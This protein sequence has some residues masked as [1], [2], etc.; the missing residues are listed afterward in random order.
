VQPPH[1][2]KETVFKQH[3]WSS[4]KKNW[5]VP[6]DRENNAN[7]NSAEWKI[8]SKILGPFLDMLAARFGCARVPWKWYRELVFPDANF[9]GGG[10]FKDVI[11]HE[12]KVE[13]KDVVGRWRAG[14]GT[15]WA[16]EIKGWSPQYDSN[17]ED[18]QKEWWGADQTAGMNMAEIYWGRRQTGEDGEEVSN[19]MGAC[20]VGGFDASNYVGPRYLGATNVIAK[21]ITNVL[22]R[23]SHHYDQK[24]TMT[25]NAYNASFYSCIHFAEL[26]AMHLLVKRPRTT[27]KTNCHCTRWRC[28]DYVFRCVS[29]LS[30]LRCFLP[31]LCCPKCKSVVSGKY[32]RKNSVVSKFKLN[33]KVSPS[34]PQNDPFVMWIVGGKELDRYDVLIKTKDDALSQGKTSWLKFKSGVENMYKDVHDWKKWVPTFDFSGAVTFPTIQQE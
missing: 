2:A 18:L 28:M 17:H 13:V 27:P 20:T 32:P 8:D 14:I 24:E 34:V 23:L 29:F 1:K 11:L 22:Y 4:T 3:D 10:D 5:Y 15:H 26:L 25:H 21:A 30:P 31:S 12:Y 19:E 16:I 7:T 9:E 33:L 6:K